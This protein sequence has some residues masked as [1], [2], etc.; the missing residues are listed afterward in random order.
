MI[1]PPRRRDFLYGLAGF[2]AAR[3]AFAQP[4]QRFEPVQPELFGASGGQPNCWADFDND[5]DLD[6][7]VGFK[8]GLPNRLYRNDGGRFVEVAADHNIADLPD[9]RAAA[10]GDF[11]AD[12]RADLFVGF[13]RKSGQA[14]KL[15]HNLGNGKFVD[16]AK[17][18]GID[19]KGESRQV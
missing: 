16:V 11:D 19:V 14:S 9:T 6:L 13:T 8:A 18:L 4:A 15:Y 3:S 10:W 2:A 17:D 12:G 5:G 7:F 1:H